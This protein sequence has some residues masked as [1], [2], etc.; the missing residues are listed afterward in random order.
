MHEVSAAAALC[1]P[2]GV[3]VRVVDM[4]AIDQD[5]LCHLPNSGKLLVFAEQ[6]N[7]YIWQSFLKI[8]YANRSTIRL[9]N[10]RNVVTI[11]ALGGSGR[12]QFIHSGT[13]EELIDAFGL[14][15]AAIAR[16]VCERNFGLWI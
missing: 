9:E 4:P 7:G 2:S 8:V 16:S 11:N 12:P 14:S 5:L 13:Y 3:N 10:L 15:S 6:N 1:E